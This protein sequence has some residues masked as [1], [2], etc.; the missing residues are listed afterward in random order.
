MRTKW[1]VQ[2]HLTEPKAEQCKLSHTRRGSAGHPLQQQARIPCETHLL[3]LWHLSEGNQGALAFARGLHLGRVER[4]LMGLTVRGMCPSRLRSMIARAQRTQ[5][6]DDVQRERREFGA[7]KN[8]RCKSIN[9]AWIT[10]SPDLQ[11]MRVGIIEK[12]EEFLII[13][14]TSTMK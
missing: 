12:V 9:L 4:M 1:Q 2:A 7:I 11:C 10:A 14:V 13:G 6:S 5:K 8:G 3:M